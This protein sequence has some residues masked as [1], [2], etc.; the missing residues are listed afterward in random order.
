MI[1]HSAWV[2]RNLG[3]DPIARPAPR[4]NL[5]LEGSRETRGGPEHAARNY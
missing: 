1:V 3:F 4:S 5:A 2:E